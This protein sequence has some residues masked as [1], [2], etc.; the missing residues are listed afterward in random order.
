MNKFDLIHNKI[1]LFNQQLTEYSIKF[2]KGFFNSHFVYF[3]QD[4]K[5]QHIYG[6]TVPTEAL[7]YLLNSPLV[8]RM[9]DE[10]LDALYYRFVNWAGNELSATTIKRLMDFT[11]NRYPE[12]NGLC[13]LFY[14][15]KGVSES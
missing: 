3:G 4:G 5:E 11:K 6:T 9:L 8:D 2:E 13:E 12:T 7:K 14:G 10:W 15:I 1:T